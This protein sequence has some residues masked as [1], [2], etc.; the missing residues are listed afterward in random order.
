MKNTLENKAKFFAQYWGQNI[1]RY[2]PDLGYHRIVND[3]KIGNADEF[4]AELKPLSQITDE[5][6]LAVYRFHYPLEKWD[7]KEERNSIDTQ[8]AVEWLKYHY[9]EVGYIKLTAE[10]SDY[11]RLKGYAVD[12]ACIS[13]EQQIEWGWI[14]LKQQ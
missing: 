2:E 1:L 9:N 7:D 6:A 8:E 11:L 4:V 13:V 3:Y 12:W 10:G 14:K 5:D